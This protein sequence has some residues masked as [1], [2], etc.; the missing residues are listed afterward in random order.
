MK[1]GIG[2]DI[3]IASIGYAVLGLNA[4]EAPCGVIR[5]GSRIFDKAEQPKTGESLAAPRREARSLR[6]R[7]RRHKHRLDRIKQLL[8]SEKLIGAQELESLYDG[9]LEDI[10]AV[11][12]RAL[13]EIL[14]NTEFTRVLLHIAQRRGFKSNR[15]ADAADKE[16]GALLK[17]VQENKERMET[18][19]YRTVGE[20]LYKDEMFAPH[21]RNKSENYL[22]TVHRDM[23]ADEVNQIF[24]AQRSFGNSGA[25]D[26]LQA[27]YLSILLSQRSFDEGPGGDSPYGGNMIEKMVGFCTFE[28]A[29][30]R[31]AKATFA[32][33]YC[34][35]LQ[36]VNHIALIEKG[37]TRA[38]V[39][40]E[41]D[42][43]VALA[44]KTP[45]LTYGKIRKELSLAPGAT[46]NMLRYRADKTQE[47]TEKEKLK[48]LC[49]Y[50]EMRKALD[51]VAKGSIGTLSNAQK[52]A[53]GTAFSLYKTD[54]NIVA[55]LENSGLEA[56]YINALL[57]M[58]TAPFAKFG[59][60]SAAACYKI[61]PFL[62]K[63]AKY[64]E[65]CEQAG[66]KFK[67]H[68]KESKSMF[69]PAETEDMESITSPVVRRAVSQTIKVI[70]SIIR[71]QGTSPSF[72]N[73]ELAREMSKNFTERNQMEKSMQDNAAKNERLIQEMRDTLKLPSPTGMDLVKYRL[74]KEQD[75]VCAYSLKH[76]PIETL[77]DA[78]VADIDHIVPYSI[79]YDDSRANKV[80]VKS[81]ENRQK[82]NRLPL[83]YLQGEAREKF[84]V[85]TN[86]NVKQYRKRQNLLKGKI[87]EDDKNRFIE[88]NLNDTKHMARF[89]YNYI[90]DYL[91]FEPSSMGRKRNVFAVNGEVTSHMRKRWG[92]SK[93]REDGDLHHA[94][95]AVVIGCTTQGMIN[96]VSKYYSRA[97]QQY[98]QSE[99][100]TY[101]VNA[102]TGELFPAPWQN[103]R[104]DIQIRLGD[105]PADLLCRLA[106]EN[107]L[108]SYCQL[109]EIDLAKVQPI[110]VSRMPRHKVTG[111]A[112]KETIKGK[113][114]G[115]DGIVTVKRDLTKLKLDAEGEIADYF[116]PSSDT[117]LYAAL[118]E[119]LHK[120]GGDAAKAFA[121]K[122]YKPTSDGKQGPLVKKVKLLEKATLNVP[123]NQNTAVADND[124]MV[125]ID[126]FY[127]E[128]EGYYFVPIY[129]ADTK[130]ARLPNKACVAHAQYANWKEM[131]E[132]NFLFSLYAGDLIYVESKGSLKLNNLNKQSTREKEWVR[133]SAFLY[134]TGAD[135]SG[136]AIS[137]TNHD[138]SYGVSG[139]GIKTLKKLEKYQVDVLGNITKVHQEKRQTFR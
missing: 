41:R 22:S 42:A 44:F 136:A 18:A 79:S 7:I 103:F 48:L 95:D 76:I 36:K 50:H 32:F 40:Q 130:K 113:V 49:A 19:H 30:K 86:A 24:A 71:E 64:N 13:D 129:V 89:L 1:Y 39:Q 70:N 91:Q 52:D 127:V 9:K 100:G 88:R 45:D 117:L 61:I 47:E 80:L 77:F 97:E 106:Q 33:E 118:K 68:D 20:M 29:E 124:S 125:R 37:Q 59:N 87:T 116:N 138:R 81:S 85:Y 96:E 69:L 112:H 17:A 66:Y 93:V 126:I 107:K 63:G 102:R 4:E 56:L 6:R 99:D 73:I 51:K 25:T 101:S 72:V 38:L 135:I 12:A 67:G 78:G 3:G 132:E 119:Q 98:V 82:G 94:L 23:I 62:E 115:D 10:Y 54:K 134:Y 131:K 92:L 60:L 14:S 137:C 65:A 26:T 55:Y 53:I 109:P 35:L 84:I 2:L 122:F 120:F 83:E 58:P 139:L 16:Q 21:K 43:V 121:E 28:P 27:E 105:A 74:W 108:P 31:A 75:G 46:F 57:Q 15:K 104:A 128:N 34:N 8:L 133:E 123:V 5:M 110:F 114:P 90:T 111:A 11:R